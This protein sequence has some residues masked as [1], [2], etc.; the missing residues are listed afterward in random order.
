MDDVGKKTRAAWISVLSN[1]LLVALKII[2]GILIGSVAVISEAIHSSVDLL[3]SFIALFAVKTAG[4][5][6]DEDH[7]FGHGK[8]ENISGTVEAILIFV[9]AGWIL[10]ESVQKLLTPWPIESAGWGVGIMMVSAILNFMVSRKLFRVGKETDSVAL[11]ADAWHLRTDVYTSLG[12]MAGL[13]MYWAGRAFWAI[14]LHW[15]D[16]AAAMVVAV[17]IIQA[18]Y[19]LTIKSA[20]DLLD[21]SLPEEERWIRRELKRKGFP[22]FGFHH[23]RTR[24]AGATRF[25]EIHLVVDKG[26]SVKDSHQISSEIERRIQD[27]F[28]N[29][30]VI[31]HVEPCDGT[32]SGNCLSGCM[33]AEEKRPR[34]PPKNRPDLPP[35]IPK[36]QNKETPPD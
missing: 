13:G 23:L 36:G 1:T 5:S 20:R 8:V 19:Q 28:P 26:M 30:K 16:P 21:V 14:N 7:P 15:L 9:A 6:P 25:A 34:T 4:K 32:C 31:I 24:R 33:V 10:Y 17:L 2:I 11:E 29:S 22:I 12:V 18:A 27:R 3:A 35:G